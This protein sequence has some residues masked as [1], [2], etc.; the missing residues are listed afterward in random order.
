M[1]AETLIRE[2]V[3]GMAAYEPPCRDGAEA[4]AL[5]DANENPFPSAYNRYPDAGQ[6]ELKAAVG[7]AKG[8][9]PL[10]LTLGNGSDELID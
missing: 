5:L 3:R 9:D 10:L 8:V 7:R 2:N 4:R 6:R 1:N